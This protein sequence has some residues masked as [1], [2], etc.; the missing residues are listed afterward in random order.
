MDYPD[1]DPHPLSQGAAK[2]HSIHHKLQVTGS[3][4]FHGVRRK[5]KR[6]AVDLRGFGKMVWVFA[7]TSCLCNST[8]GMRWRLKDGHLLFYTGEGN[9]KR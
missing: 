6:L 4:E 1:N 5:A 2:R 7:S 3:P 8:T 9:L